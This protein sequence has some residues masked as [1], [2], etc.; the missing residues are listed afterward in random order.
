MEFMA[1]KDL[2]LQTY[3]CNIAGPYCFAN[4]SMFPNALRKALLNATQIVLDRFKNQVL[5]PFLKNLMPVGR[6]LSE[7]KG[8]LGS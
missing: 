5:V 3:I 8:R 7:G 1:W 2:D 4:D 6:H